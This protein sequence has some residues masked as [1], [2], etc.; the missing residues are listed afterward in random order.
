MANSVF[1]RNE[2]LCPALWQTA[3]ARDS[4][5]FLHARK[6]WANSGFGE[7]LALMWQ[8]GEQNAGARTRTRNTRPSEHG[9][10]VSEVSAPLPATPGCWL[11]WPV[12]APSP[13]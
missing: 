5:L 3:D 11:P 2:P 12:W 4:C 10:A 8:P 13:S 7:E 1:Q 6:R 9:G